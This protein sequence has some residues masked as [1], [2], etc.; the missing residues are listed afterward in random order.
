MKKMRTLKSKILSGV[1]ALCL[2]ASALPM[3]STTAHAAP[4]D[5][6][7]MMGMGGIQ[8]VNTNDVAN[9]DQIVMGT[10]GGSPVHWVVLGDSP[11]D[12]TAQSYIPAGNT[13][14][15]MFAVN[16][17]GRSTFQAGG[18]GYYPS[19]TLN[20]AMT[21]IYNNNTLGLTATEQGA[22]LET[23]LT[24][25]SM[26]DGAIDIP[27]GTISEITGQRFF[28]LSTGEFN[29]LVGNDTQLVYIGSSGAWW[30]RSSLNVVEAASIGS[31]GIH[32]YY[33]VNENKDII[34][35]FNLNTASVLFTSAA[36]GGKAGALGTFT[37]I[38]TTAAPTTWKMTLL[39]TSRNF[40]LNGTPTINGR[41][42]T[43]SYTGA[44]TAANDYISVMIVDGAG[45]ITHYAK[46][47]QP[48]TADGTA[49]FTV[50]TDVSGNVS[51]RIFNEQDNGNNATDY[52]SPLRSV[53][54]N[55]IPSGETDITGF[56]VP[57]Q[58]GTSIID[59]A[60]HTVA[61]TMPYGTNVTAL[62][63]SITLS[64]GATVA[65]TSGTAQNFTNPVRYTVTAQDGTTTQDWT[66]TVSLEKNDETDITG[67]TVP[68]QVGTS[69]I[70]AA[71]HTVA[72]TMPYGT[73]V[74]A[75]A[76]SIT[77]SDG[78]TIS[79]TTAQDFTNPVRYTVTAQDGATTQDWT[80]TVSLEKNDETDITAF[81]IPGQ[82]L[83]IV[84]EANH[85]VAVTM[86]YGTDVTAL[87]PS[88][89]L[90]GGASI[91][92]QGG[93]AQNF[94]GNVTYTVTAQDGTTSQVWTVAVVLEAA[95]PSAPTMTGGT[96]QAITQ[97]QS[98]SFTSSADFD[99]Y[100]QTLITLSGGASHTVHTA[101]ADNV[102]ASAVNGSI[103]VTLSGTYT[104][105]LPLGTHSI[106]INSEQGNATASFT[107]VAPTSTPTPAPTTALSPQ[108]GVYCG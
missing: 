19:S 101:G 85:T 91:S 5:R 31:D 61:V 30:L 63:P 52:S 13:G 79:P 24:A 97:G 94:T 102:N 81:S 22:V 40:A 33:P 104:A 37:D 38:A 3:A 103:T 60:A 75:L 84:S 23:S 95:P 67:F 39:D 4:T 28:P 57:N 78:A 89:T 106:S 27:S 72:L 35:A 100:T 82:V 54:V 64:G 25:A 87:A 48:T 21:N 2:M 86:P 53:T 69:A 8:N 107:V 68:N 93:T 20:A 73:D 71:A 80:V 51:F 77:L 65:P 14:K 83:S 45:N 76:P 108:T 41:Q 12:I 6:A 62:A 66:V 34:P 96:G 43:F 16:N 32:F 44:Q 18:S 92:P 74:T 98:A 1:L 10:H 90:S 11:T 105:T 47:A 59:A 42:V 36:V 26:G 50:P 9:S 15:M 58:V 99:R 46:V 56:T 88:I 29:S 55:N 17:L 70:D 7:M 49:S